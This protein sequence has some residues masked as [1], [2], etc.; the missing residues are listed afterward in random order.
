M[1]EENRERRLLIFGA[2]RATGARYICMPVQCYR[3]IVG[4]VC[5][6]MCVSKPRTK[7]TL[8]PP[9]KMK[10]FWHVLVLST[11]FIARRRVAW[12]FGLNQFFE[13]GDRAK[14]SEGNSRAW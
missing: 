13:R 14:H 9:F 12:N 7:A 5:D 3:A 6:V 11:T 4:K 8:G 2:G 1:C 10:A